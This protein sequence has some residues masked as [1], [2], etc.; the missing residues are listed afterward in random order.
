MLVSV[1]IQVA[2][3]FAHRLGY[4]MHHERLHALIIK[5]ETAEWANHH[6]STFEDMVNKFARHTREPLDI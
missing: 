1:Q 6:G 5:K 3:I 4:T 2:R